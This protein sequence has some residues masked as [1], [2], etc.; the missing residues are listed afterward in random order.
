MKKSS[1]HPPTALTYTYIYHRQHWLEYSLVFQ[2]GGWEGKS[3]CSFILF[4]LLL[5]SSLVYKQ[6]WRL[7]KL[8]LVH[9]VFHIA[10]CSLWEVP[11]GT[12]FWNVP[13]VCCL[14]VVAHVCNEVGMNRPQHCEPSCIPWNPGWISVICVCPT[15]I[16]LSCCQLGYQIPSGTLWKYSPYS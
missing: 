9:T 7:W 3:L 11:S 16:R 4:W 14:V 10:A 2:L 12:H 8:S 1:Y 5:V 6:G 15:A 13:R